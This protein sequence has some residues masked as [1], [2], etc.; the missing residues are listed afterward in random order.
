MKAITISLVLGLFFLSSCSTSSVSNA[1]PTPTVTANNQTGTVAAVTPTLTFTPTPTLMPTP[2]LPV[3]MGTPY[4]SPRLAISTQNAKQIKE[5]ARWGTPPIYSWIYS[6]DGKSLIGS[7]PVGIYIYDAKTLTQTR[8]ISSDFPVAVVGY[9]KDGNILA[10]G[11]DG[12]TVLLWNATNESAPLSLVGQDNQV[13]YLAISPDGSLLAS[14]DYQTGNIW[15]WDTTTGKLIKT[16][17][18]KSGYTSGLVFSPDSSMLAQGRGYLGGVFVWDVATGNVVGALTADS[19]FVDG[20]AFSPD[21]KNV[22]VSYNDGTV[23][24]WNVSPSK[25]IRLFGANDKPVYGIAYSPDGKMIAYGTTDGTV[26]LIDTTTSSW[27]VLRNISVSAVNLYQIFFSPD[28][29]TLAT[30]FE[31]GIE[32]WDPST[33]SSVSSVDRAGSSL[34]NAS[35]SADGKM[36]A[37]GLPSSRTVEMHDLN[38]YGLLNSLGQYGDLNS[39]G[40]FDYS[41]VSLSPDGGMAAYGSE[42]GSIRVVNPKTGDVL[43]TLKGCGKVVYIVAFSP[44]G[45]LFACGGWDDGNIH[46][47][48]ISPTVAW[49]PTSP[50]MNTENGGFRSFVFSPDGQSLASIS[51]CGTLQV[52]D[53]SKSIV[54]YTLKKANCSS[55]D[56]SSMEMT[57]AFSANGKLLASGSGDGTV[58]IW[59]SNSGTLQSSLTGHKSGIE[60]LAFSPDGTVLASGSGLNESGITPNDYTIR[61]WNTT[62]GSS[63]TF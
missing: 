22:A 53:A 32:F 56:P 12:N 11:S 62:D 14:A 10:A 34:I 28:G 7:S 38:S 52:W 46:I 26:Q 42:K 58:Q 18:G 29:K 41:N 21:G 17:N 1:G 31:K 25:P 47:Y 49:T 59:N 16:L 5:L 6:P 24:V 15:I 44:D 63:S 51:A 48:K 33:G 37:S 20:I 3:S 54:R 57:V 27:Q 13:G 55:F 30:P 2:V 36:V 4:P 45:K 50:I 8:L 35:F 9:S 40:Y 43:Q 39:Y 19:F 61:L 60:S 23:R